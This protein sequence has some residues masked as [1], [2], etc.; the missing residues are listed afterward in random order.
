M[1]AKPMG[2][3]SLLQSYPIFSKISALLAVRDIV[4]L[5]RTCKAL[6]HLHR[7][8]LGSNHWN[9]DRDL[10][11][12]VKDPRRLREQLGQHNALISG[13][14]V[15]QFFERVTWE[16]SDLDIFVGH[17][18]VQSFRRYLV[19]EE[20]YRLVSDRAEMDYGMEALLEVRC[21]GIYIC[22]TV[23]RFSWAYQSCRRIQSFYAYIW[24]QASYDE[25]HVIHLNHTHSSECC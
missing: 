24:G 21:F 15:L 23:P 20:G 7:T 13:S 8:L 5:T 25:E 6:S 22:K 4:F 1:H 11:R 2:F 17:R 19:Q 3:L 10:R 14:F 18:D 9:V 16:K 12:F